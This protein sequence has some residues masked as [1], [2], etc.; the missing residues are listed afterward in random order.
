M[1]LPNSSIGRIN[2][3]FQIQHEEYYFNKIIITNKRKITDFEAHINNI[4]IDS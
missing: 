4:K 1:I 3:K 2:L